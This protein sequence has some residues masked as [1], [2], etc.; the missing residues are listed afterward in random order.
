VQSAAF[1]TQALLEWNSSSRNCFS[2]FI[3]QC[4]KDFF[5]I[6]NARTRSALQPDRAGI[7]VFNLVVYGKIEFF[8]KLISIF[9][10]KLFQKK[11]FFFQK[12]GF[13]R[14]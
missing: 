6:L 10:K 2:C 11:N 4:D 1:S 12:S 5:T 13:V 9:F 3:C 7:F 8:K 14:L